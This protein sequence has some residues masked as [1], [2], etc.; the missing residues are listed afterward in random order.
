[1]IRQIGAG[2]MAEAW[3]ALQKG[4][5]GF[6]RPVVIKKLQR[7]Q[8]RDNL[9]QEAHMLAR[10]NHPNLLQVIDFEDHDGELFLVLEW[11]DGLNV[12]QLRELFKPGKLP[13]SVMDIALWMFCLIVHQVLLALEYC[14]AQNPAVIH[15][16]VTPQNILISRQGIVKLAD[17]GI[18]NAAKTYGNPTHAAPEILAGQKA[19]EKSDLFQVGKVFQDLLGALPKSPLPQALEHWVQKST[20]PRPERRFDSAFDMRQHLVAW[21]DATIKNS[22]WASAAEKEL[23]NVVSGVTLGS[24]D[25][26]LTADEKTQPLV[27][28]AGKPV[29]RG[30]KGFVMVLGF[31]LVLGAVYGL[32]PRRQHDMSAPIEV[33]APWPAAQSTPASIPTPVP[34]SLPESLEDRKKSVLEIQAKPWGIVFVNTVRRGVTPQALELDPGTFLIEVVN[35]ELKTS[36]KKKVVLRAGKS[37]K[38]LFDLSHR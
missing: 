13:K 8:F 21:L 1:M 25:S 35:P 37:S 28:L 12:A 36:A 29:P 24:A 16:D 17:F 10:L 22:L 20:H 7:W 6:S 26:H 18:A 27:A 9:V 33:Q 3:L 15:G 5:E 31:G 38:V 23:A 30:P 19:S 2:G 34:E 32:W 14:H 4:A 11:V